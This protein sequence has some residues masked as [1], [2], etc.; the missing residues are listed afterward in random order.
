MTRYDISHTGKLNDNG[1]NPVL[2]NG[3]V[4]ATK[5]LLSKFSGFINRIT[6]S[7]N[8]LTGIDKSEFFG[9]ANLALLKAYR[10]FDSHRSESFPAYAKFIVVDALNEYIRQNKVIITIPRYVARANRI[11]LRIKKALNYDEE[12]FAL[13]LSNKCK[14]DI[15]E[16]VKKDLVLLKAAADRAGTSFKELVARSEFLPLGSPEVDVTEE[17]FSKE[18]EHAR[19]MVKMLV[20]QIREHLTEEELIITDYLMEGLNPNNISKKLGVSHNWVTKRI[21]NI[22]VKVLKLLE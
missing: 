20:D 3:S 18:D 8:V 17:V 15:S 1:T 2:I 13:V 22:R 12:L 14:N 6:T 10:D 4:L 19:I 21:K 9:E 11:I 7:Y 16:E 5:E